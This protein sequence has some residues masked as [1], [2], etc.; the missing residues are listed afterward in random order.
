VV[1]IFL[2]PMSAMLA[3][4]I[5]HLVPMEKDLA[6]VGTL[7]EGQGS[8]KAALTERADVLVLQRGA[9]GREDDTLAELLTTGPLAV[10][11]LEEDGRSGEVY[12]VASQPLRVD[13]VTN[14][15]ASAVRVAA[16]AAPR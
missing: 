14:A 15:F 4:M 12:R 11:V 2:G 16:Q 5:R 8:L 10:L 7:L 1:R 13:A 9:L 3:D 6:V